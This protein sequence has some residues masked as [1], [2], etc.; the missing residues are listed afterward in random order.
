MM[1]DPIKWNWNGSGYEFSV[2]YG[3]G[4]DRALVLDC[5]E[6]GKIVID[7]KEGGTVELKFRVQCN[8]G[9]TEAI[10]GKLAMMNGQEVKIMLRAPTPVDVVEHTTFDPLFPD[11]KPDPKL[12]A[13][14]VFIGTADA[15]H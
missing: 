15:V 14:D 9:L 1:M 5:V 10:I 12:T 4:D 7:P 8:S 2:D 11:Y 3:L 13:E 6:V